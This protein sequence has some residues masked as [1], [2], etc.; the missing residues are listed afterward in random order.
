MIL[1]TRNILHYGYMKVDSLKFFL[2]PKSQK[3]QFV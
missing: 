3:H 1:F 2:I